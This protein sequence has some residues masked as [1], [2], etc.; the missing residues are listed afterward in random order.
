[1]VAIEN[2]IASPPMAL[3]GEAM[4][5]IYKPLAKRSESEAGERVGLPRE[6]SAEWR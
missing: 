3:G 2:E 5:G 4:T 1:M 6:A